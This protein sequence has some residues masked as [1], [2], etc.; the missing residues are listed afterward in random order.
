MMSYQR[1]S[2]FKVNETLLSWHSRSMLIFC[3]SLHSKVRQDP[4]QVEHLTVPYCKGKH[5]RALPPPQ[6][7]YQLVG[8]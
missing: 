7:S 4:T 6:P 5:W 8:F 2:T 1:M 3:H